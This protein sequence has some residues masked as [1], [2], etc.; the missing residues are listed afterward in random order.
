MRDYFKLSGKVAL[1]TG[2][3]GLLGKAHVSALLDAG[4][5]VLAVDINESLFPDLKGSLTSSQQNNLSCYKLDI[6]CEK[7]IK[8][9]Q[10]NL[11][12]DKTFVNILINNAAIDPKFKKQSD[13][14]HS[15]RLENFSLVEWDKQISVGLTGAYL[16]CKVFGES[17]AQMGGGVILNIASDLSVIA[18]D[19]RLYET[20]GLPQNQQPVKPI[21]YSVIKHGLVG[22][23]KYIATYWKDSNVR[24]N[25]LSPGGIFDG[26]PDHFVNAL[27]SR[28]PLGRMANVDDYMASVLYLCSDA[29][30]YMTGQNIVVDGGRSIW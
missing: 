7:S 14:V 2:G 22:L 29:S 27:V 15:S 19:Q 28:I 1:I 26:Q 30:N 13:L 18:P 3:C 20:E 12:K 4:A 9:L 6:S 5:R 17:M 8:D 21:T 25:A 24:C 23:T 16:C 10:K 11:L